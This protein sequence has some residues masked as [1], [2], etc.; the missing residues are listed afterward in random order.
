MAKEKLTLTELKVE[1]CV[2]SLTGDQLGAIKG[3]VAA[4]K[5][6]RQNYVIRWTAIDTRAQADFTSAS[7]PIV[8]G[9]K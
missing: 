3:G 1:S 2:T 6:R 9:G 5:G 4:V 7:G 8:P